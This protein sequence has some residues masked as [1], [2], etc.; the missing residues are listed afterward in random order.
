MIR[1]CQRIIEQVVEGVVAFG[2]Y[3]DHLDDLQHFYAKPGF[4]STCPFC[5]SLDRTV[6]RGDDW[7]S[8]C[9]KCESHRFSQF[10][11]AE[12]IK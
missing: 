11:P 7:W 6:E 4:Q 5:R 8:Y 9:R 3:L 10:K 2:R 12:V 1:W